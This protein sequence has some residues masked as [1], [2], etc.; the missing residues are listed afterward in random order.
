MKIE[1]VG[2]PHC[3]LVESI[4]DGG[5]QFPVDHV[6]RLHTPREDQVWRVT[7]T[8]TPGRGRETAA[9]RFVYRGQVRLP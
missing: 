3:G 7:Y 4:P 8:R 1:F 2:G 9:V 6:Q 5:G